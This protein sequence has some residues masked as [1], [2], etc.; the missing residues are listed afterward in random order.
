MNCNVLGIYSVLY[1]VFLYLY[2]VDA[3]CDNHKYR[4]RFLAMEQPGIEEEINVE[5]R[6]AGHKYPLRDRRVEEAEEV[7]TTLGEIDVEDVDEHVEGPPPK[8]KRRKK[9]ETGYVDGELAMLQV[10]GM[11]EGVLFHDDFLEEAD[12]YYYWKSKKVDGRVNRHNALVVDLTKEYQALIEMLD[13]V[14]RRAEMY[15]ILTQKTYVEVR[16][17]TKLPSEVK[18]TQAEKDAVKLYC[19]V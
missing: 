11:Y 9:V 6:S 7:R 18:V 5:Y 14:K 19:R 10:E 16:G 4:T 1:L 13:T 8:R 3:A 12:R 17:K 2:K 15:K